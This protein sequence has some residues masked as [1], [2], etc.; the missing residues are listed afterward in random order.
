GIAH[1]AVQ[2][3]LQRVIAYSSVENSGLIL[4]GYGVAL[5]GTAVHSAALVAAG[6]LAATLQIVAHTAAKSLLF[7]VP[8]G[9][10]TAA[11]P[12]TA[13]VLTA[14]LTAAAATALTRCAARRGGCPGAGP[15]WP[16]A[17]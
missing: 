3:R 15:G 8:A 10:L 16:L 17:R 11:V 12:T 2:P 13:A 6:L 1:A 14:V 7:T 4:A 9:V 5:T